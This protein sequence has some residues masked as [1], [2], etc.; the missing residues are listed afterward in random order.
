[1]CSSDLLDPSKGL[2]KDYDWS[3]FFLLGLW[4]LWL[5]RNRKAF[6][7]QPANP[8]LVQV[9]EMQSRE[10]LY[11]VLETNT[12]VVRI[13]KQ[14]KW[15]KPPEG[16]HKLNTDGSV[17]GSSGQSGCGGLLRDCSGQWVVGFAKSIS[18]CSSIA[19]KLWTLREGLGLCLE[20]G[21]LAVEIELDSSTTISLVSNNLV[22]NGDLSG[23]VD[24]CREM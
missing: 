17:V 15:L 21:I 11:C 14:I 7:Q 2:G 23:L 9:V 20:N 4:N 18:V 22:S 3:H 12:G 24:D 10:L 6:E 19:A 5:Q 16:W 1:M 8:N 13:L